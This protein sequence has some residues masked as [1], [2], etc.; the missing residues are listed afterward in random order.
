MLE[1]SG[2]ILENSAN[3]LSEI[4]E[5][6]LTK[7]SEFIENLAVETVAQGYG[8]EGNPVVHQE[9]TGCACS[10]CSMTSESEGTDTG[11]GDAPMGT[12]QQFSN[13]MV[14]RDPAYVSDGVINVN[15]YGWST[16]EDG[17]TEGGII[18][19][20][21]ALKQVKAIYGIDYSITEAG[22]T[23]ELSYRD[24]ASGAWAY[25]GG[26]SINVNADW[27][28]GFSGWTDYFA[29]THVHELGHAL[30]LYHSGAYNGSVENGTIT[31]GNDSRQ[32]SAM[33]YIRPEDNE[34]IEGIAGN[35]S[36]FGVAD[37]YALDRI[38]GK[39][40]FTSANAFHGDTVYGFNTTISEEVSAV[41][42]GFSTFEGSHILVFADGQGEDTLDFSG[43]DEVQDID[44]RASLADSITPSV[45]F[46]GTSKTF[47]VAVGT[48]LENVITGNANDEVQ[49]NEVAN[50]IKTQGGDD[51]VKAGEGDDEIYG[52]LGT[53][54]LYGDAGNDVFYS[55][56]GTDAF[57]GGEDTDRV[58]YS[59]LTAAI[60]VNLANGSLNTGGALGDTYSSIEGIK[61]TA[62]DDT[63]S[64]DDEGN[65]FWGGDGKDTIYG[66]LGINTLFGEGGDDT[67]YSQAGRDNFDGGAGT[68]LVDYSLLTARVTANLSDNSQNSGGA[69][70]DTYVAIEN[71]RGTDFNDRLVGNESANTLYGGAGD[72][73]F[74]SGTGLDTVY[75]GEGTDV[76][77][78]HGSSDALVFEELGQGQH[79]VQDTD[80]NWDMLYDMEFIQLLDQSFV[81]LPQT[82]PPSG[83]DD[84]GSE[85]DAM[86]LV[87]L[88]AGVVNLF[89]FL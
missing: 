73:V 48:V 18:A 4:V 35:P 25:L 59:L 78:Y 14:R 69:V 71:L 57:D 43:W 49:G 20:E 41:Y 80:G 39:H 36:T 38:L 44:L 50:M 32:M 21:E 51:M 75:G 1:M 87:L 37:I 33:S 40:G 85:E 7:Q 60:T 34:F 67:F 84:S 24:D 27:K 12:I 52:G 11:I 83:G 30:G 72:D 45:S 89:L 58:D 56:G 9:Q 19:A 81:Q 42:S 23:G 16:D 63:L 29:F 10:S 2:K 8:E 86:A 5:G 62:F 70:N 66:G 79:R 68:D 22:V 46:V 47:L 76:Y 54:R 6:D 53:N 64:G 65:T 28:G 55:E 15:F 77:V 88:S 26:P 31:F 61:G 3:E 82:P 17:L 13:F 74:D